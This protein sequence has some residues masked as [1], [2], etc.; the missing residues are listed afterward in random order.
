MSFSI[1][2]SGK[3]GTG[4]TTMSSLIIRWFVKSG[5]TPVLA[6]DADPNSNLHM[7]LGLSY[8]RT[9]A[10][11]RENIEE[12]DVPEGMTKVA[13]VGLKMEEAL[14]ESADIDLLVM[15]RPE[16]QGCYCAANHLLKEYLSKLSSR[17]KYTVMDNEAGMEHLSRRTTDEIDVLLIVAEPT[18]VSIRSAINVKA[19]AEQIKLKIKKKYLVI[20]KLDESR[21]ESIDKLTGEIE[22]SGLTLIQ[23]IP[24]DDALI[25][26]S[27]EG[28]NLLSITDDSPSVKAVN[29]M[30]KEVIGK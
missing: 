6:V 12:K 17:Y 20:N 26:A 8:D 30:M 9:I 11:I 22:K 28:K 1:A 5:I 25:K 18:M 15:G 29:S 7:N 21:T 4:K 10:G 13:Y 23:K 27:E 19:T 3:G 16:G 24:A 14:I 2:V